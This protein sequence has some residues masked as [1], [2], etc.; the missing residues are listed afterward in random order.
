MVTGIQD[1]GPTDSCLVGTGGVSLGSKQL[2]ACGLLLI[3]NQCEGWN[4]W[5]YTSTSLCSMQG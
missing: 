2:A 5:S 1:L 4:G 3:S